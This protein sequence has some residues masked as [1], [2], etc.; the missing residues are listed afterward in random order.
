[1]NVRTNSETTTAEPRM[2][3]TDMSKALAKDGARETR[4][5]NVITIQ[6]IPLE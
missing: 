6:G 5:T 2:T 4:L 1:M 3:F